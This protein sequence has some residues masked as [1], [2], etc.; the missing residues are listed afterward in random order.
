MF[1][2]S[3]W[4]AE[5]NFNYLAIAFNY[6]GIGTLGF[7]LTSLTVPEDIV[8][9]VE[10]PEG[11]GERFEAGDLAVTLT[12][13]RRLTDKFSL[14]GNL[15][16]IQQ[17]IWHSRAQAIAADLGALFV[18]PFR[19]IRIGA[20]LSNF[21]NSLKMD[22]RDMIISV[23]P[24]KQ[25]EGNVEFVNAM[26]ETDKFPIP[27]IFR[28][29]LAGEIINTDKN[30]LSLAIDALHPNDNS[31]WMNIGLEYSFAETFF[32]RGGMTTLFR[33]DTEEGLTFGTGINYKIGRSATQLKLDYSYAAFGRLKNVQRFSLGFKF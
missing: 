33:K 3:P 31:E 1:V 5:T 11:T 23:D 25:N 22:G 9:T 28:V 4:I 19:D 24:D 21:G 26:Y 14:G 8:R 15:K 16:F 18:T 30:R 32:V 20:S 12:Y 29:G 10:E 13:S 2:N 7:S 17:K 27:L 6:P